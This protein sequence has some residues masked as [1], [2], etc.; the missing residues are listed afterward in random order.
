MIVV[1]CR[2]TFCQHSWAEY[3]LFTCR[4]QSRSLFHSH[5]CVQTWV[6][7]SVR[8]NK[9]PV[10]S[11]LMLKQDQWLLDENTDDKHTVR[12]FNHWYFM[13]CLRPFE[14]FSSESPLHTVAHT[15]TH[16]WRWVSFQ[17]IST[18]QHVWYELQTSRKL[19]QSCDH[20]TRE[21]WGHW[22]AGETHRTMFVR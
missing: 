13:S 12:R 1:E 2:L 15:H 19:Q 21:R 20:K 18:L 8:L 6:S 3:L 9:S 4:G 10:W 14:Y 7:Y 16:V 11:A 17:H 5:S 22:T